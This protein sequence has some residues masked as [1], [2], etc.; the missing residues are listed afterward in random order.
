VLPGVTVQI[1]DDLGAVVPPG[2]LG[3][4]RIRSDRVA[5]GYCSGASDVFQDGWFAPG[6]LGRLDLT[7]L[8]R[9]EG[10]ADDLMNLG[11]Q[12]VLPGW[13]ETAA[14]T[15]PGVL[16]AAAFSV[17]DDGGWERCWIAIVIDERFSEA[18]L[19]AALAG[20]LLAAEQIS[21]FPVDRLPRGGMDKV[22]RNALRAYARTRRQV[23]SRTG[24]PRAT[25]P[26]HR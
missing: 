5:M 7:G 25:A 19:T 22:D 4:V 13:V 11:G 21:W 2:A 16:E 9:L 26:D 1:I 8:L 20:P 3:H 15:C 23:T 24:A 12:K 14:L 17:A 10:R 18:A 6:D